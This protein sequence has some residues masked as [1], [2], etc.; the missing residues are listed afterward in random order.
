MHESIDFPVLFPLCE[1]VTIHGRWVS[2]CLNERTPRSK[3]HLCHYHLEM[4]KAR[5]GRWTGREVVVS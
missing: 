1:A 4:R 3:L 2:F 5:N